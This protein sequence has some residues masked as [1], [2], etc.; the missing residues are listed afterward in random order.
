MRT[1]A[2]DL[3]DETSRW[4]FRCPR[5]H[6]RW[7]PTEDHFYCRECAAQD[8]GGVIVRLWD[9]QTNERLPR[10]AV[11]IVDADSPGRRSEGR[12]R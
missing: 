1:E 5:G 12:V 10:E 4:R 7:K 8:D 6:V 2:I 3:D 11:T 9:R